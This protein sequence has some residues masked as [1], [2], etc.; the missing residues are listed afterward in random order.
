MSSAACIRISGPW[1]ALKLPCVAIGPLDRAARQ[2]CLDK[3][4]AA[5]G[6]R[7]FATRDGSAVAV[8]R[9]ARATVTAS[10]HD[11]TSVTAASSRSFSDALSIS[12]SARATSRSTRTTRLTA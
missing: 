1:S 3:T 10:A 9:L 6:D 2:A 8:G 5:V 7:V 11:A 12:A 4:D